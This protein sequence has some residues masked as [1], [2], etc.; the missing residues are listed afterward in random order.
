MVA[1]MLATV[2]KRTLLSPGDYGEGRISAARLEES[3]NNRD[4]RRVEI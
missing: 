4:R 1:A 3:D 2:N